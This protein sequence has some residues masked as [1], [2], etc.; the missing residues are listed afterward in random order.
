LSRLRVVLLVLILFGPLA[1]LAV[2]ARS[3]GHILHHED[4]LARADAIV[5]LGGARLTRV[6]EAGDLHLAR[7]A[8]TIVLSPQEMEPVEIMLRARGLEIP[9]EAEI[10]RRAL[11][12]MGVPE[13]AIEVLGNGEIATA[14]EAS[15]LRAL[16]LSREWRRLIIVTSKLHTARAALTFTRAFEGTGIDVR[17]RASRYDPADVDRWW[18]ERADL[19]FALFESQKLAAYWLG[20]A[21]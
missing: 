19:R 7:W 10:Q 21:D 13:S 1:S 12:Q 11:V 2:L 16:A 6:A 4:P 18:A 15:A 14:G 5:V 3:L 9:S 20:I 8:P 17:V